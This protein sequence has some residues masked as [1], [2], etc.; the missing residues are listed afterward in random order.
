VGEL[1]GREAVIGVDYAGVDG[2]RAPDLEAAK[3]AGVRF[4][5]LRAAFGTTP[6]PVFKRDWASLAAAGIVRGAYLMPQYPRPGRPA[7]DPD[8]QAQTFASIVGPLAATDFVPFVDVEFSTD[9]HA[10]TGL[11]PLEMLEWISRLATAIARTYGAQPGIYISARVGV[12]PLKGVDLA[13]LGMCPLWVK[14]IGGTPHLSPYIAPTRRPGILTPPSVA[15][16]CPPAWRGRWEIQQYQ[17]DAI[18]VPG[19]SSTVD[20]NRWN[21]L[22]RGSTGNA[23]IAL[24]LRLGLPFVTGVF[25]EETASAVRSFQTRCGLEADGVVGPATGARLMWPT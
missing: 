17:G 9:V 25:D 19:F 22:A 2:D 16:N 3:R 24:Q 14:G 10:E 1:Q 21:T 13:R 7:P 11:Q 6:D 20:L 8:H 12:E 5:I 15:P 4:A 18:G 23:V